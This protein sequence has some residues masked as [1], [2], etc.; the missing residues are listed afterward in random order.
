MMELLF[1]VLI[2]GM[3]EKRVEEIDLVRIA[4]PCHFVLDLHCDEAEV[5]CFDVRSIRHHCFL[6]ELS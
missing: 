3:F 1:R 2:G 5:C 6:W 4:F